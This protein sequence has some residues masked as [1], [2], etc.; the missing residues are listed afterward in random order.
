[1]NAN[2]VQLNTVIIQGFTGRGVYNES[3]S[4]STLVLGNS[5]VYQNGGV[6]VLMAGASGSGILLTNT[7]SAQNTYGLAMASGNGGTVLNATLGGNSAAGVE[8]DPGASLLVDGSTIVGNGTGVEAYGYIA[9]NNSNINGNGTGIS[10][11]AYSYGNNRLN[12]NGS[13]GTTPVRLS[14]E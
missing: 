3:S 10:G 2:T 9:L 12:P 14:L 13:A 11:T 1:L 7:N 5:L 4:A 6:G 8:T